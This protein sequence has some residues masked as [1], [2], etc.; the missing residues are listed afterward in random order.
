MGCDGAE[1]RNNAL[2]ETSCDAKLTKPDLY[3]LIGLRKRAR[4]SKAM[5]TMQRLS[6]AIQDFLPD[7]VPGKDALDVGCV[8]HTATLETTDTWLHKYIVRTAN[9]GIIL[10]YGF[11]ASSI[12]ITVGKSALFSNLPVLAEMRA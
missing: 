5:C 2:L 3:H 9:S 7:L 10:C 8:D 4:R 12:L 6:A 1:S 11:L